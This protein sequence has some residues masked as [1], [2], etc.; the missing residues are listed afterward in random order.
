MKKRQQ[1]ELMKSIKRGF[2]TN[3]PDSGWDCYAI[4]L[5]PESAKYKYFRRNNSHLE[6]ETF[7]GI[8]GKL[9][10][11][12]ELVNCGL[13]SK[14]LVRT[15]L[16]NPGRAGCA[17][18]HR[19]LWKKIATRKRGALILEDDCITHPQIK[20][21]L[22]KMLK[23]LM[24]TDITHLCIN[25]DSIL[26]KVSPEGLYSVSLFDPKYPTEQWIKETLKKTDPTKPALHRFLN[27]FG[28]CAYFLS[29]KGGKVLE[30]KVF[31]LSLRTTRIPLVTEK[32]P[33]IGMDRAANAIYREIESYIF[34][35]FLA[36]TP[37]INS[38]TSV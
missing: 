29:P 4:T 27:G 34:Q 3:Q 15:T 10:S 19:E 25:T 20:T 2:S 5:D 24:R 16:L 8:D 6:I 35:P 18:S 36:Y 33:A 12:D 21:I 11:K 9:F 13:A 38:T 30:Q 17:L 14:E 31:P 28:C 26:A 32:M 37:N 23:I 22:S 1:D 7:P